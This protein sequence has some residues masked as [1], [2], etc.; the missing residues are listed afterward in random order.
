MLRQVKESG[1]KLILVTGR[2]LTDLR[3][4]FTAYQL[5]DYI[6]AENEALIYNTTTGE[7]RLLRHPPTDSFVTELKRRGIYPLSVGKV[8]VATW[9]PHEKTVLD[10]IKQSGLELQVIFNKG[11][12]MILPPG[13]NKAIGLDALLTSLHL[14]ARNTVAIGDAENDSAMLEMAEYAVAVKN[15]LPAL[16]EKA[17]IVTTADSSAGVGELLLKTIKDEHI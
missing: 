6:V 4:V 10:V 17:D 2:E 16:K 5:F 15:A 7:E 1:R 9:E 3:S 13:I 8:I 11:A 12:V 14:S